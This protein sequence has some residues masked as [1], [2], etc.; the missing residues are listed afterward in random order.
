MRLPR[1]NQQTV[2][3]TTPKIED[4]NR[5]SLVNNNSNFLPPIN[6][7][8]DLGGITSGGNNNPLATGG[9]GVNPS[10]KKF[11]EEW[12]NPEGV[13]YPQ[14][15]SVVFPS[16]KESKVILQERKNHALISGGP[17][18]SAS[19]PTP[20]INSPAAS[21]QLNYVHGYDG[22]INNHGKLSS[23]NILW[24]THASSHSSSHNISTS[25]IAYPSAS[26]VV[27]MDV[28]TLNQ[29]FF[30]G[31]T[32]DVT[33]LS[34][35]PIHPLIASGQK[36]NQ[37]RI[38]IWNYEYLLKLKGTQVSFFFSLSLSPFLFSNL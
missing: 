24:L 16:S 21:L 37:S 15:R 26:L 4:E 7:P 2:N 28:N 1:I 12:I 17:Y 10:L 3:K 22:D 32:E 5:K 19:L 33:C 9:R 18:S 27:V 13:Q 36:G 6:Q 20:L 34:L 23:N 25:L 14:C 35:H 30:T 8:K 38:L 31:H 11:K 29:N